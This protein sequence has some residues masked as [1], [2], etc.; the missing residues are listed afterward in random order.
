MMPNQMGFGGQGIQ[1][2]SGMMQQMGGGVFT[3]PGMAGMGVG[4]AN[5]MQ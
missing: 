5:G 4:L 1:F 2:G 3:G